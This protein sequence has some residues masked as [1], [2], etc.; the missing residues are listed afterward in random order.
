MKRVVELEQRDADQPREGEIWLC[1]ET[2]MLYEIRG[3]DL[4]YRTAHRLHAPE[5]GYGCDPTM[6]VAVHP[7]SVQEGRW[8]RVHNALPPGVK[9]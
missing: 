3:S 8:I 2:G 9:S 6:F 7:T 4:A 1:V 5:S